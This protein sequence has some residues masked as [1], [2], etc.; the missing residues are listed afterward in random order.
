MQGLLNRYP[1]PPIPHLLT[2]I[3]DDKEN[4][5]C[6]PNFERSSANCSPHFQYFLYTLYCF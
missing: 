1:S 5:Q 6:L 3:T 4:G 2:I